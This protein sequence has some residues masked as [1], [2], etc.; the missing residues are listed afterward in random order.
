[1]MSEINTFITSF[2]TG[3]ILLGFLYLI[4][5]VGNMAISVKYIFSLCFVCCVIGSAIAIP[6]PDFTFFE[7]KF[8]TEILTEQ[9]TAVVAQ[10]IFSE[11]LSS[12]NIYFR[13]IEVNT[14]KLNDGSIIIS[15]I[16]VYTT[17][18]PQKVISIIGSD[19]YEVVV[20]NE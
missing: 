5:P 17:E 4:C 3:C 15:K 12:E 16:I 13:K 18:S 9:N 19:D 20:I 11:A 8:N 10:S 1:M 14:N 2:C 7:Q 6:S